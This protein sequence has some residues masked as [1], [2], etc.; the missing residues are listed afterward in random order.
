MEKPNYSLAECRKPENDGVD[1]FPT[2][3]ENIEIRIAKNVCA[4]CVIR[5]ACL[6]DNLDTHW[7]IIG[8]TSERERREIRRQRRHLKLV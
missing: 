8:N 3:G 4:R 5:E 2:Q 1:F 7:G 6:E